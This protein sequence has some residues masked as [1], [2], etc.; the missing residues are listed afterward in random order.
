MAAGAR[1][2]AV[3]LERDAE[4]AVLSDAL[5][6]AR[7]GRGAI[8]VVD[9][10]AGIGK[11]QLLRAAADEAAATQMHVLRAS[12]AALEREL[13]YGCAVALLADALGGLAPADQL[14]VPGAARALLT[15]GEAPAGLD[16]TLPLLHGLHALCVRLAA[17]RPLL[18][19]LDDAH[20][21]D[22]AS[23]RLLA[24]LAA[25]LEELPAALVVA[26]RTGATPADAAALDALR[27]ADRRLNPQVLSPSAV[28]ECVSASSP[29]IS[30]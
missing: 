9:G 28:A 23:L 29:L 18:L 30:A 22:A 5:A 2:G 7:D 25:R 4:L 12:G 6:R 13:P 20:D 11:T 14:A 15:G 27:A 19:V 24:Y 10:P 26:A 1:T 8:V 17:T 16:P 3:L 21:A